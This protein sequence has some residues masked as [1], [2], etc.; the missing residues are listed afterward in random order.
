MKRIITLVALMVMISGTA[1]AMGGLGGS[2]KGTCD[3]KSWGCNAY[4]SCVKPDQPYMS[5]GYKACAREFTTACMAS[6][7]PSC[8]AKKYF[9]NLWQ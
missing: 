3:F 4:A 2:K 9:P 7:S 6:G 5:E 1:F 8:E